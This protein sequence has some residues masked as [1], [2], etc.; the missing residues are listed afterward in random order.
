MKDDKE[1]PPLA[2]IVTKAYGLADPGRMSKVSKSETV[3]KQIKQ[4]ID[5][6]DTLSKKQEPGAKPFGLPVQIMGNKVMSGSAENEV[7]IFRAWEENTGVK[8]KG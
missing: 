5:L 4:Y 3:A 6:Y 8:P 2:K 7:D 1:P